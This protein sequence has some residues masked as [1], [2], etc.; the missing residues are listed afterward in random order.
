[1][2]PYDPLKYLSQLESKGININDIAKIGDSPEGNDRSML[3]G[4]GSFNVGDSR[5]GTLWTIHLSGH[6]GG[7]AETEEL[8]T[9]LTFVSQ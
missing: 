9:K 7:P 6:G 4:R 3:W 8:L 2:K 1:M 5:A